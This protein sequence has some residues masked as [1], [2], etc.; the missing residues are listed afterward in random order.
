TPR[1]GSAFRTARSHRAWQAQAD[2]VILS[3]GIEGNQHV[4]HLQDLQAG[5]P[6][7]LAP[8]DAAQRIQALDVIRG[9]ALFGIFLM[10]IEWF[11]Q[12]LQE[13]GSGIDPAATGIDHAAAW[14]VHVMVAG[15]FWVLFSLLF[16]M[17]F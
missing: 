3:H 4:T 10:N 6:P 2:P 11:S 7:A 16:G 17:G 13:M 8:I 5:G 1:V 14:G 9:F 12:P 15:K